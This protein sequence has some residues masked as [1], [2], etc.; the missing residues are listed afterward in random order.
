VEA[1]LFHAEE[2]TDMNEVRVAFPNFWKARKRVPFNNDHAVKIQKINNYFKKIKNQFR[3]TGH[4][5]YTK[6]SKTTF[7]M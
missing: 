1:K 4:N 3:I 7:Q 2:Q 5:K 6:V